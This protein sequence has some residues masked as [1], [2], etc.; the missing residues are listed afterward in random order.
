M[1]LERKPAGFEIPRLRYFPTHVAGK[2]NLSKQS[3]FMNF[4]K[5]TS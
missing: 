4:I 5:T 2:K 3:I 1:N